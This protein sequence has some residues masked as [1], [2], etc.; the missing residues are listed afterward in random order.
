MSLTDLPDMSDGPC[1]HCGAGIGACLEILEYD[2]SYC[3]NGCRADD[4]TDVPISVTHALE[5][6]P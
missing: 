6:G 5:V 4:E 2:G 3:C 1:R